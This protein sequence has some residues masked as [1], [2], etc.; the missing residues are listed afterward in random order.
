MI[1]NELVTQG[2]PLFIHRCA[3]WGFMQHSLWAWS[4]ENRPT[5]KWAVKD[6]LSDGVSGGIPGA[7]FQA[8]LSPG[9]SVL[10]C[11]SFLYRVGW[12]LPLDLM[13]PRHLWS[14][15]GNLSPRTVKGFYSEPS[16]FRPRYSETYREAHRWKQWWPGFPLRSENTVGSWVVKG[17]QEQYPLYSSMEGRG[18]LRQHRALLKIGICQQ[19]GGPH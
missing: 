8:L 6:L 14:E 18:G 9:A 5:A 3:I 2:S 16:L 12:E 15:T 11:W 19:E 4:T 7:E 10:L 17:P 13:S 1:Q